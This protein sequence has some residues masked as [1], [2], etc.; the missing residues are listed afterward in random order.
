M[1]KLKRHMDQ[2]KQSV[3]QAMEEDD[4][5][6]SPFVFDDDAYMAMLNKSSGSAYEEFRSVQSNEPVRQ[7]GAQPGFET[8]GKAQ[9]QSRHV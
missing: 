8:H 9:Q 2:R 3:E 7:S 5:P 6:A 4:E 1:A